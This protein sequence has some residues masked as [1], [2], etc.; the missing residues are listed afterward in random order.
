MATNLASKY[1]PKTFDDLIEQDDLKRILTN[2]IK[3]DCIKQCLL[4]VGSAGVG[5]TSSAKILANYLNSLS[6]TSQKDDYIELDAASHNSVDDVRSIIAESELPS[7]TSKYKIFILD[8]VHQFSSGAFNALLKLLEEPPAHC[9]YILC[10]TDPQKIPNTV[11]S[12]L[13]VFKLKRISH[14]GI[15]QRLKYVLQCEGYSTYDSQSLD[16]IAKMSDGGM[17]DAITLLEKCLAYDNLLSLDNVLTCL[18]VS[19]IKVF[20]N[21][22]KSILK[23]DMAKLIELIETVYRD[24]NDIKIFYKNFLEFCI[25]VCKY[26]YVKDMSIL[27]LPQTLKEPFLDR[28]GTREYTLTLSLVSMLMSLHS[29]MRYEQNPKQFLLGKLLTFNC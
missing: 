28:L 8:E 12:R 9:I 5:K 7:M 23:N 27:K 29:Q 21:L 25:D 26:Q 3:D 4:F 6:G 15:V 14:D 22:L 17:R 16:Y 1:R 2:Q 10:T 18:G 20:A 11:L 19:N 24:G 13:Q